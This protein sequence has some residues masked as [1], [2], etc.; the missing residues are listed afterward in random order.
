MVSWGRAWN[1]AFAWLAW[2]LIYGLIGILIIGL[3]VFL[4]VGHLSSIINLTSSNFYNGEFFGGFLFI[5]IGFIIFALGAIASFFKIN[6]E[7]ISEEVNS[8]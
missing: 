7:I 1:G 4:I 5:I 8:K 6:S 3:G 2:T